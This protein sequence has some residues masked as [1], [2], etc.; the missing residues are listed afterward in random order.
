MNS[1]LT[2]VNPHLWI[3]CHKLQWSKFDNIKD[4]KHNNPWLF[5][6]AHVYSG[7]TLTIGQTSTIFLPNPLLVAYASQY[8]CH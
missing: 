6:V 7:Q 1:T 4:Y 3:A 8:Q 2:F 5:N